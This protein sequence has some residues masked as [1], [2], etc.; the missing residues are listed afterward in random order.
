MKTIKQDKIVI[1]G[2]GKIGRSFIGQLFSLGG[3]EVVFVDVYKRIIDE[4]NKRR[5][6]NVIIKSEKEEVIN[7]TNVRGVFADDEQ[8]VAFEIAT[9]G[10]VAVSVGLNGLNKIFPALSKGLVERYAIDNHSSLDIIIAENMRNADAFF[11]EEMKKFM[12]PGYPFDRLVGLVETSIGK[13]VPIMLKK[14]MEADI[15]QVFAE[16]YNTLILDKKGFKNPI[17]RIAGLSPKENMKAWV[18][19]KLF[20]HNLGHAAAAYIG[21]L[22]N[23]DVVYLHE[24]LA[25]P[26][27]HDCVR[28]TM[29]QSAD[30]LMKKYPGEFSKEDLT[31]HI[32]DLLSRFQNKALGDTIFRVGCDLMRKLG[33]EDR[34]AGAIKTAIVFKLPY[35]KILFALVCGFHFRAT[36]EFGNMLPQD[37]EFARICEKGINLVLAT[38]CGFDQIQNSRLFKEAQAI[39]MYISG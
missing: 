19:C 37:T 17:P 26:K 2:A 35:D 10:L 14:D 4:L 23:P 12:P 5:N 20:I 18:D 39:D 16:P 36:D 29:L 28:N 15:L 27:V 8:S 32:N 34:M 3:Y 30:I 31:E 33:P 24:A 1:F 21:Y 9:A 13:M 22:F 25:V 38:I 6:Y 7:I 11:H